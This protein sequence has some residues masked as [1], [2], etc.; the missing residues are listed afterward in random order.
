MQQNGYAAFLSSA[1]KKAQKRNTNVAVGLDSVAHHHK[2]VKVWE[3]HK[4]TNLSFDL[5]VSEA[6]ML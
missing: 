1:K 3:T 5:V 2:L 6:E 4:D